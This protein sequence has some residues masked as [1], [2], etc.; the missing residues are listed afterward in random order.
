[1]NFHPF[2][3]LLCSCDNTV[4]EFGSATIAAHDNAIDF[5]GEFVPLLPL[6][7]QA[8]L[9]WMLGNKC[10]AEFHGCVYLSSRELLR[11]VDLEE[12]TLESVRKIFR[13]NVQLSA[14]II[15]AEKA[16][17]TKPQ[18]SSGEIIYLSTKHF[19]IKAGEYFSAGDKLFLSAEVD[20][21]T[22]HNLPLQVEQRVLLRR[23]E[24]LLLCS[25]LPA[26]DDNFIAL[27]AYS[28]KLEEIEKKAS[29]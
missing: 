13:S 9:R 5:T 12:D 8:S 1:M 11:I 15:S 22:L 6:G 19:T 27:S 23:N 29:L 3:A 17:F 18:Y 2:P 25:V 4:Q 21:L 24:A 10:L 7:T 26:G 20:F 16:G 14:Q 28:A